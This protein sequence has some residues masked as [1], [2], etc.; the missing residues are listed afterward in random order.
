MTHKKEAL[1]CKNIEKISSF[2]ES[3]WKSPNHYWRNCQT[4]WNLVCLT[5]WNSYWGSRFEQSFSLLGAKKRCVKTNSLN[6]WPFFR[7][8]NQNRIKLIQ[9]FRATCH[10]GWNWLTQ[11][12]ELDQ[13][14][15]IRKEQLSLSNSRERGS[16]QKLMTIF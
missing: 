11:R 4:N 5:I 3:N 1:H 10:W 15:G 8:F 12:T 16:L 13:K 2:E 7:N 9:V 14:S 6:D